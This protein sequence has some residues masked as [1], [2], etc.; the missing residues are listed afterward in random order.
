MRSFFGKKQKSRRDDA[1]TPSIGFVAL[2]GIGL[3]LC[4]MILVLFLDKTT[5]ESWRNFFYHIIQG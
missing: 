3:I 2:L 4:D 5:K 1:I